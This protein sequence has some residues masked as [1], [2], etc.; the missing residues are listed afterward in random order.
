MAALGRLAQRGA[1]GLP[2][3]NKDQKPVKQG[4]TS[5]FA[6]SAWCCDRP[7]IINDNFDSLGSRERFSAAPIG[8]NEEGEHG[9]RS[10][11]GAF[12]GKERLL[13]CFFDRLSGSG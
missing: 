6:R 4:V 2:L 13:E 11:F 10:H 9:E 7:L 12:L 8:L 1:A 5:I 3:W